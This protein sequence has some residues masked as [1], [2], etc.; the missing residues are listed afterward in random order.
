MPVWL[1]LGMGEPS[2]QTPICLIQSEFRGQQNLSPNSSL[3]LCCQ[4][5]EG[6]CEFTNSPHMSDFSLPSPLNSTSQNAGSQEKAGSHSY[7]GWHDS[8]C[9]GALL[10][11]DAVLSMQEN[12]ATP[13][14]KCSFS[15]ISPPMYLSPH[16]KNYPYSANRFSFCSTM[17]YIIFLIL[18]V[19]QDKW[20]SNQ[21]AGSFSCIGSLLQ[22]FVAQSSL[23]SSPVWS[24]PRTGL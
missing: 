7:L 3:S 20:Q 22:C 15:N 12:V 18:L 10:E 9:K 23:H 13:C 1:L 2:W 11:R 8:V 19:I 5:S 24:D 17:N 6:S 16:F 21:N 4:T 14:H